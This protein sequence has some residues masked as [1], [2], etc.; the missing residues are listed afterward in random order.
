MNVFQ[1]GLVDQSL[2]VPAARV[3]DERTKEIENGVVQTDRDLRLPRLRAD[4]AASPSPREV[5][6]AIALSRGLSHRGPSGAGSPSTR[7]HAKKVRLSIRVY[8]DQQP[9]DVTQAQG[10]ESWLVVGIGIFSSQREV[11]VQNCD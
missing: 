3:F 7:D 4:H 1:Q 2:V 9:A 5:D 6:L 10:H 8:D 11:V